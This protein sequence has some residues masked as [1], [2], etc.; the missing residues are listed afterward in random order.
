M[1][2]NVFFVYG[3]LLHMLVLNYMLTIIPFQKVGIIQL[4][5]YILYVKNAI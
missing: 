3:V 1:I 5:I 2:L 4:I